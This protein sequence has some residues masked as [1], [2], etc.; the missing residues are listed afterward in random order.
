M[1][2]ANSDKII[3]SEEGVTQGDNAA[4]GFYS[5]ST[6][7]VIQT[8]AI[9]TNSSSSATTTHIKQVW[10]ADD[11]AG[12]GKIADLQQWWSN[13]CARGPL[14]GYYPKPS[15]TWVIVKPEHYEEAKEAFPGLKI[16]SDGHEYLGSFIGTTKGMEAFV[17][18]KVSEWCKDLKQ[19]SE[20]AS[21][22]PQ[23]AYSAFIIWL[24]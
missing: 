3:L 10:Y 2:I 17:K 9:N 23:V 7:P 15:K 5:C 4:M 8:S 20:I 19:L 18:D 12:G 21:R 14:F 13:L 11:A 24:I 1:Y 16:T 6:I 22:E